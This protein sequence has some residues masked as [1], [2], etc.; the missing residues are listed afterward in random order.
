VSRALQYQ[1]Q[2]RFAR[3]MSIS[4]SSLVKDASTL[5][6]NVAASLSVDVRSAALL[7]VALGA[8]VILD[9]AGN[10]PDR[11]DMFSD[12]VGSIYAAVLSVALQTLTHATTTAALAGYRDNRHNVIRSS[13]AKRAQHFPQ[14]RLDKSDFHRPITVCDLFNARLPPQPLRCPHLIHLHFPNAAEPLCALWRRPTYTL[15]VAVGLDD[16]AQLLRE[17]QQGHLATVDRSVVRVRAT[18]KGP[19]GGALRPELG[20]NR[21]PTPSL[22]HVFLN[23][24]VQAQS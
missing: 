18:D 14:L 16:A 19:E 6:G 17:P 12:E 10:W 9:F 5:L 2:R 22:H 24:D 8:Y 7:R 20:C 4:P 11:C 21:A 23:G 3:A 15:H 13:L 1:L